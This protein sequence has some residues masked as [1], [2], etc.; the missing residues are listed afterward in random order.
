MCNI[1]NPSHLLVVSSSHT[2]EV[3]GPPSKHDQHSEPKARHRDP[4]VPLLRH[5]LESLE[6]FLDESPH[7][8]SL[9]TRPLQTAKIRG[10][11]RQGEDGQGDDERGAAEEGIDA[12]DA[13]V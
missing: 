10:E 8:N 4:L 13:V 1:H 11:E 2:P 6:S 12:D 5:R 7:C 9:L 3:S